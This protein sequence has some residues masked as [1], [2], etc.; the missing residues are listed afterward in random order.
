M[1]GIFR[2]L[3]V[4]LLL[5][6]LCC[7]WAQDQVIDRIFS[8]MVPPLA[9]TIVLALLNLL[10]RRT[11]PRL[12]LTGG[13]IAV[14]YAMLMIACAMSGEWMDMVAPSSYGFAIYSEQNPR[15]GNYILP[16]LHD[17]FFF[18]DPAPLKPLSEGGKTFAFFLTQLPLWWPKIGAWTLLLTLVTT[19]MLCISALLKDQWVHKE[20]LAFP[21][22]QL[23]IALTE[24]SAPGQTPLWRSRLFWGAFA[25]VFAIDM[26]NGLSFLY[27]QLPHFTIRFLA[28]MNKAFVSPPWNQTGWTPIGI[29]PYLSALGFLM[30]TD[31]LFSLLVFFFVRKGQQLVAYSIGNEQGVFGGGGLNPSPPY[32]SEQSWGAFLGLFASA[33]WLARPHLKKIWAQIATGEPDEGGG[34]APRTLFVV[35]LGC[36]AGMAVIGVGIG[37]PLLFV[38]FYVALFLAF[39]VAVTRLRASLGAPTHEMAFMGPHQLVL[40]FHGS[41]GLSNELLTRTLATFHFMNRIHRT[42][43]M[44]S[45]MEGL[46]LA[47][48]NRLSAKGMFIALFL[49]IPLGTVAGFVM[50]LYF[51]YRYTPVSWVSGELGGFVSNIL[52]TPRPPNPSAM[53]AVGAGFG[54]VMLLDFI[55]FRIPGFWLHPAGYALA[56][57]FGIDYYWFGLLVV[58]V[59]K[60]FFQRFYGLKGYAQLRQVAF[61]LVVG[62]FLAELIWAT[63]S[64]LNDRQATY[65]ISING[66]LGWDQ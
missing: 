34:F 26:L 35:F 18:R 65:S 27:P 11:L 49:A 51:G 10:V 5:T 46:Y 32:F 21:L 14:V 40:D 64:M 1:R 22:V 24:Q 30:P 53:A 28:D 54:V 23:P 62:E 9:L 4:G 20:R 36:I 52:T 42:H 7:Y 19:A 13:E 45:L 39:S 16:F 43:P 15:Y 29:F 60:V 55:R 44:P 2:P 12:A 50:H 61:G 66:K 33:L 48:R 3:L 37:L 17:W 57:N 47:D 38:L 6:P 31:L 8:L 59:V 41:A 25:V 56:M 58:L 63:F